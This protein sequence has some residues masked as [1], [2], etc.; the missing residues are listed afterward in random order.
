MPQREPEGEEVS[1][2]ACHSA[3]VSCV[4]TR[5]PGLPHLLLYILW[6]RQ[7]VRSTW[8]RHSTWPQVAGN[9]ITGSDENEQNARAA[10][11]YLHAN[12]LFLTAHARLGGLV[13]GLDDLGGLHDEAD[14]PPR[15]RR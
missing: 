4:A 9:D 5:E 7:G 12:T 11:T 8:K 14:D 2:I 13:D 10:D 3:L 6:R 1:A 15:E